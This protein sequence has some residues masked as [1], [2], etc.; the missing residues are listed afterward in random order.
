MTRVAGEEGCISPVY[1]GSSMV[2]MET[3]AR[4]WAR[5]EIDLPP[6]KK[7]RGSMMGTLLCRG[8]DTESDRSNALPAQNRPEGTKVV[9]PVVLPCLVIE[10]GL[11]GEFISYYRR[12]DEVWKSGRVVQYRVDGDLH[13]VEWDANEVDSPWLDLRAVQLRFLEGQP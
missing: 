4:R 3:T 8:S 2:V 5:E 10:N 6:K 13:R 11:V 1:N 7:P 9:G 12:V